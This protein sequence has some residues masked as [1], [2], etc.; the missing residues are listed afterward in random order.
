[1]ASEGS[2]VRHT[3]SAGK[4]KKDTALQYLGAKMSLLD[5]SFQG[6][7]QDNESIVPVQPDVAQ[8][9]ILSGA[10]SVATNY[11]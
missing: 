3:T 7:L 5:W 9:Y 1:M 8:K 10:L 6:Q 2:L 4:R 11:L